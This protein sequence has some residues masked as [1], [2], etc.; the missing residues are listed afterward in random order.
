VTVNDPT[1]ATEISNSATNASGVTSATA[2]D[3]T[4][5]TP[6]PTAVP[7]AGGNSQGAVSGLPDTGGGPPQPTYWQREQR[8]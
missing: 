1:G 8:R 5:V 7:P 3:T 2:T 6:A 4:P